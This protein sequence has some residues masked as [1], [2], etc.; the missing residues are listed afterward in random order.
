MNCFCGNIL[1]YRY[2]LVAHA[3]EFS[4]IPRDDLQRHRQPPQS[5]NNN[6]MYLGCYGDKL[7]PLDYFTC[8]AAADG[9][10]GQALKLNGLKVYSAILFDNL[11]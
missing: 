2:L 1:F 3:T 11:F 4:F 6:S 5:Q 10:T 9:C 8:I 7:R